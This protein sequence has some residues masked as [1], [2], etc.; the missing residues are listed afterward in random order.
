MNPRPSVPGCRGIVGDANAKSGDVDNSGGEVG[1]C[2]LD[3]DF[4][5]DC[6][7]HD[8]QDKLD[9]VIPQGLTVRTV[10]E[11]YGPDERVEVIDVKSQEGEDKGCTMRQWADYYESTGDKPV[12]NVISLEVSDSKLGRLIKRPKVVRDLDLQDAVWPAEEKAKGMFPKVQFYC[13]MSV[14]D[15]YTDFHIDFG[16]SSVYYHIIRG[17]KTFFFIPPKKQHLKKYEEWCNSADQNSTFLGDLTKECYRVDLSEGDTMLIPSGWIHSVWTPENSLVIGGNFLTR[18]HYGMQIAVNEIEKNTNVARKFR[19]PHFQKVLWHALL[20]YLDEDPVPSTVVSTFYR[21]QAF[22][23]KRPVYLDF[24]DNSG[25][26]EPEFFNARYYSQGEIDGLQS[27][28]RYI[29]RTVMVSL[30]KVQGVTQT[31]QQ[32]VIRSIPKGYGE[33][34]RLVQTFAMW[35]A[36]KRGNELIPQWALPDADASRLETMAGDKKMSAAALKKIERKAA[37]EAYLIAPERRSSRQVMKEDAELPVGQDVP[38]TVFEEESKVVP[39]PTRPACKPCRNRRIKCKHRMDVDVDLE[40]RG[41]ATGTPQRQDVGSW[42][43]VRVVEHAIQDA[44]KTSVDPDTSMSSESPSIWPSVFVD[45]PG[46]DLGPD[47]AVT[48]ATPCEAVA[49]KEPSPDTLMVGTEL[50]TVIDSSS[51]KAARNKACLECRKSKV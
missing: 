39:T 13:L 7:F 24:D 5:Y 31:T 50:A 21:G 16:G 17:K 34:L 38:V 46:H 6:V 18:I 48:G 9:M 45:V 11:L 49:K 43:G 8:G 28:L 19:Y 47:I 36:W 29:F 15:C 23:R 33:P 10:S 25:D 35:T 30:G 22:E 40:S 14:A 20:Q 4:E 37:H 27:L 26:K 3:E 2:I 1:D 12:R 42:F 51:S 44:A 32:A 41:V